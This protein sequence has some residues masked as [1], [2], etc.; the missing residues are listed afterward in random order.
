MMLRIRRRGS[1]CNKHKINNWFVA[2]FNVYVFCCCVTGGGM[3]SKMPIILS[4]GNSHVMHQNEQRS[5]HTR[6]LLLIFYSAAQ[7]DKVQSG[8]KPTRHCF[9]FFIEC[10]SIIRLMT[11]RTLLFHMVPTVLL[12]PANS[13]AQFYWNCAYGYLAEILQAAYSGVDCAA[14]KCSHCLTHQKC[15]LFHSFGAKS[16]YQSNN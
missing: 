13:K 11:G 6:L 14:C 3:G 8:Q 1:S 12:P 16:F 2:V 5:P 15:L 4:K 10:P 9:H 7:I